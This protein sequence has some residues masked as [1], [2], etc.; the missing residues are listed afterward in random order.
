MPATRVD[1]DLCDFNL[2][3]KP[4]YVAPDPDTY[5]YATL[6][7]H[8]DTPARYTSTIK[9]DHAWYG[10]GYASGGV[11]V[12]DIDENGS[13]DIY[14]ARALLRPDDT[15]NQYYFRAQPSVHGDF[16]HWVGFK[17]RSLDP[18]CNR[19]ALG[20]T[21]VVAWL[22][23]DGATSRPRSSTARQR[24]R[25]QAPLHLRVWPR[26]LHGRR[27]RDRGTGRTGTQ[28]RRHGLA[29]G[30][31][32]TLQ[33]GIQPSTT[34]FTRMFNPTTG[35]YTWEFRWDPAV[36]TPA[37]ADQGVITPDASDQNC[38]PDP[39]VLSN[40][41]PLVT[42]SVVPVGSVWRHTMTL[43]DVECSAPC[44]FTYAVSAGIPV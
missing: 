7:I 26:R 3:G 5:P 8:T 29:S 11:A 15:G 41:P 10:Q 13:Q 31:Y 16:G 44:R 35:L 20:A 23:P 18:G 17:L 24:A 6:A 14:V 37:A 28:C 33:L 30:K 38:G 21:V 34:A 9:E 19:F 2:D 42:A 43:R 12:A 39:I 25:G 27:G 40:A 22:G 32:H 4:D 1:I 36:Q